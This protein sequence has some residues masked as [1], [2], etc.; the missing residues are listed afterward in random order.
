MLSVFQETALPIECHPGEGRHPDLRHA[1][2]GG[3]PGSLSSWRRPGSNG[4]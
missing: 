4:G 1:R 3:H 2:E